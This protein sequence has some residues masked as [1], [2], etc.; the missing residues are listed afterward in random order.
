VDVRWRQRGSWQPRAGGEGQGE[1]QRDRVAEV[2]WRALGQ[3]AQ[4]VGGVRGRWE[5]RLWPPVR[6][7][8]KDERQNQRSQEYAL[9][10]SREKKTEE[11]PSASYQKQSC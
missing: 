8:R 9:S 7:L 4:A 10:K 1:G 2:N 6:R 11:K 5:R 3:S